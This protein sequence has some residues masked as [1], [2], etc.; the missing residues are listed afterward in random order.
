[1]MSRI[2]AYHGKHHEPRPDRTVAT[3]VYV[4]SGFSASF[5]FHSPTRIVEVAFRGSEH[6][7]GC[8]SNRRAEHLFLGHP[9]T[10]RIAG[11]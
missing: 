11:C 8:K 1:M 5:K 6:S 10:K 3:S 9:A 4:S 7:Q 2:D